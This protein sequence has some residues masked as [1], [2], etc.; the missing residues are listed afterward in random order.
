MLYCWSLNNFESSL[1]LQFFKCYETKPLQVW[2]LPTRKTALLPK[3]FCITIYNSLCKQS[4]EL[5][6][7]KNVTENL[8]SF[9]WI[10]PVLEFL[11]NKV[12]GLRACNF[13][14]KDSNVS[15]SCEIFK[16]FKNNN[17]KEHLQATVPMLLI[18][19]V[20]CLYKE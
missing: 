5:H 7:K 10:K 4:L 15:V 6:C 16:N 11:F 8:R 12:A 2:S 19:K 9:T 20:Y 1:I 18:K 13:T 14:E 3:N 17:F